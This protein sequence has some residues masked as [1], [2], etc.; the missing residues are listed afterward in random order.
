M[1]MSCGVNSMLNLRPTDRIYNSLPLYHTAGGLIGVGQA[2]LRGITVVLRRRF[3]AS[4]FWPDC[5][6]YECTVNLFLHYHLDLYLIVQSCINKKKIY[7]YTWIFVSSLL[8]RVIRMYSL[9]S[10]PVIGCSVH[11]WDMSISAHCT[12]CPLRYNAQSSTDVWKWSQTPDMETFR[13]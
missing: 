3:S 6:H 12:G 8:T 5:V 1:L 11:R 7:I 10:L 4:K 9:R 2:L 13:G